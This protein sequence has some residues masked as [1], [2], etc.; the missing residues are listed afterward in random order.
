MFESSL[1]DLNA[2]RKPR[3][4]WIPLSIA[5]AL[6]GALLA[7]VGWAQV[8]NVEAVRELPATISPCV[9]FDLRL[10]EPPKASPRSSRVALRARIDG[11]V[12]FRALLH[13]RGFV[14]NVHLL[15]RGR[16]RL[17]GLSRDLP[18]SLTVRLRL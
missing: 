18:S 3:H 6:H 9:P 16:E 4:R 11:V 7:S 15:K 12:V 2:S 5:I 14:A 10:P 17:R 13:E 1:I 8:W